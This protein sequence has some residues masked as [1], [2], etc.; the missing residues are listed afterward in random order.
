[1]ILFVMYPTNK[2]RNQI[3]ST[4]KWATPFM[5]AIITNILPYHNNLSYSDYNRNIVFIFLNIIF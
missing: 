4:S 2:S 5:C 3:I 1:M